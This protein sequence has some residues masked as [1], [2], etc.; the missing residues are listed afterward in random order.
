MSACRRR[1][2]SVA[3][4]LEFLFQNL[5]SYAT[6]GV[7]FTG[8]ALWLGATTLQ[9]GVLGSIGGF[10]FLAIMAAPWLVRAAGG[11]R[12]AVLMAVYAVRLCT[13]TGILLLLFL[14]PPHAVWWLVALSGIAHFVG[15]LYAPLSRAWISG[16]IPSSEH[17]R[18]LSNRLSVAM[19][20]AVVAPPL[21]GALVDTLPGATGFALAFGTGLVFGTIALWLVSVAHDPATEQEQSG[22]SIRGQLARSLRFGPFR[23]MYVFQTATAFADGLT[24]SFLNIL[25]LKYL[26]LSFFLI[27]AF[28]AASKGTKGLSAFGNRWLQKRYEP[29]PLFQVSVALMS[30]TPLLLLG[31]TPGAAYLVAAS[32]IL[33]EAARGIMSPAEQTLMMRWGTTGDQTSDFTLIFFSRSVVGAFTPLLTAAVLRSAFGLDVQADTIDPRPIHLLII[34]GVVLKLVALLLMPRRGGAEV[35]EDAPAAR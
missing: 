10:G 4:T 34:A 33:A 16:A 23:R 31:A 19:I 13:R 21:A 20:G 27:N 8:L 15:S 35:R 7:V 5:F 1:R 29:L 6:D 25:Y 28:V 9:I 24:G 30:L 3:L 2:T 22:V 14:R 26:G 18:F 32:L 11:S 17:G 12:R